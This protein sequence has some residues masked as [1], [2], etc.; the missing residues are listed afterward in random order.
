MGSVHGSMPA[1]ASSVPAVH[2]WQTP[3]PQSLPDSCQ[4]LEVFEP[5]G[6]VRDKC[7]D[8]IYQIQES[9]TSADHE[10][11]VQI[12][13]AI[14]ARENELHDIDL[15]INNMEKTCTTAIDQLRERR[16]MLKDKIFDAL[17]RDVEAAKICQR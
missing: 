1:A 8:A 9:S 7:R 10:D 6:D 4:V 11:V 14:K 13:N 2:G 5:S 3:P 17:D 12:E 15:L 16:N